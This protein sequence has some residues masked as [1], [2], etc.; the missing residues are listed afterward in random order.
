[1]IIQNLSFTA[2]ITLCY[3]WIAVLDAYEKLPTRIYRSE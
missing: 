1:M 2:L 3:L